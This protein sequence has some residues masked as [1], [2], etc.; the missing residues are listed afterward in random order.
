MVL[1]LHHLSTFNHNIIFYDTYSLQCGNSSPY[2]STYVNATCITTSTKRHACLPACPTIMFPL[3]FLS[4]T[5]TCS[6]LKERKS[7]S[8]CCC[9]EKKSCNR[10]VRMRED[11]E[12]RRKKSKIGIATRLV[13][14]TTVFI[15]DINLFAHSCPKIK[16]FRKCTSRECIKICKTQ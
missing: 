10:K 5:L 9:W 12:E 15:Y 14:F 11:A 2:I 4:L 1:R 16:S 8:C 6:K 3:L 7:F 13:C